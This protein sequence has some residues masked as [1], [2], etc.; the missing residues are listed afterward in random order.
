[1]SLPTVTTSTT[2]VVAG[3]GGATRNACV[4]LCTRDRI[5]GICEQERVTRVRAA[6]FNPSGLPDEAL[7]ELLRRSGR[8]RRDI[9]AY[10]LA[11]SAPLPAGIVPL[12][13]DHHFAHACA[14]F[15]PSGF[16]SATIVVCDHES[17][18]ISV[19]EGSANSITRVEWP[20]RGMGF[21][22]LYSQCAAALGFTAAGRG[23][24]MEALARLDPCRSD[25]RATA[26]FALDAEQI[27]VQDNWHSRLGAWVGHESGEQT[28]AI[29]AALQSRIGD[30]LI[31]FLA[32]V[33]AHS[34]S[35]RQLCVGGSLFF[36]SYLNSRVKQDGGFERV[37]VPV[38]PG[39][40]GLSV[41]V[42]LHASGLAGRP[43]TPFLGPTYT[44]E[45]IKSTLDNCKLTYQWASEAETIS[46]AVEALRKGRL[47]AWFDGPME[48]GPRALGGRSILANPF[49]PYVLDNLNR[50][51]KQREV[52]RGYAISALER[53]IHEHFAGPVAS[54][55]MECDY[56]PRDREKFRPVLPGPN[57]SLR[58]QTVGPDGPPRFQALLEAFGQVSGIPMLVNTSFNGFR[59]PIV[60]SPRDAV[61]VFFG[62]GV[63]LLLFGE[64]VISK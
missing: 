63:D 61:R 16:D 37:F 46:I 9:V 19:W 43:V 8:T 64:F 33:R 18:Q 20:W 57:A 36:N 59:E 41:G 42:A 12:R 5:L 45:D 30:L 10:A 48:W 28:S 58:V 14:A 35:G 32:A 27:R 52:W 60:C 2:S 31:E 51:L 21:A 44:S 13:L 56:I 24:R 39:N 1:L 47:I 23:Q 7:D 25:E 38:N 40:A 6:G 11:E 49:A 54:P 29:A 4:T 53:C 17:P 62:T 26:L 15:L 34:P 55:F 22:E 3:L 50:F